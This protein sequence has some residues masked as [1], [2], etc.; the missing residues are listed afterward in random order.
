MVAMP[1]SGDW[2]TV[3]DDEPWIRDILVRA[4]QSRNYRCQTAASAEEALALLNQRLTAVVVTDLRMP[5]FNG[6][7]LVREIKRRWPGTGIIIVTA[8][9]DK[10]G[11]IA[12]LNAGADRYFLKPIDLAEFH[13][14]LDATNQSVRLLRQQERYREHLE[15]EVHQQA[16]RV[17]HTFLSAID[18]LVRT[19]EAR[20]SYTKGH[21]LRVRRYA[22]QLGRALDLDLRQRKQLSLAAKLH[23]IGKVGTPEGILNKAGRLTDAEFALVRE[24]PVMGE[25]ILRPIIRTPAV[26]AAI[27][28]HHERLDGTGYPDGLKGK[29]IPLLARIIAVADCFDSLT[30]SR[31]YRAAMPVAQALNVLHAEAGSHFEPVFVQI[32]SKIA[33]ASKRKALQS[34]F[35]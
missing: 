2:V 31:A 24:H 23:D 29:A 22:L 8:G 28:G 30:T 35:D 14:A 7:W 26:L 10:E 4:A 17:R 6:I 18:S 25:R 33:T 21:S 27:R 16:R 12:C 3:V 1:I 20:H 9:D 13:H 5:G 19:L 34:Q 32:F 15:Q 11:A